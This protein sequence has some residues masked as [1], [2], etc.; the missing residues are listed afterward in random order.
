MQTIRRTINGAIYGNDVSLKKNFNRAGKGTT[1]IDKHFV[2]FEV[3][4]HFQI[5]RG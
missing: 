4:L 5:L 2:N 3:Y 1:K